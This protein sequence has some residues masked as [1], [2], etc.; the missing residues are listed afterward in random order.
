[1][2]L[3]DDPKNLLLSKRRAVRHQIEDDTFIELM[4]VLFLDHVGPYLVGHR[5]VHSTRLQPD[6]IARR[7]RRL[8]LSSCKASL[9]QEPLNLRH[10][11]VVRLL[12]DKADLALTKALDPLLH[13]IDAVLH[14]SDFYTY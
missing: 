1:M 8:V 10:L 7:L 5:L 3:L 14:V 6:E 12:G 11:S 13:P 9:D 4:T 2:R